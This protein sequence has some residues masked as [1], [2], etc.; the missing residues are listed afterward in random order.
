VIAVVESIGSGD[1][2]PMLDV[3]RRIELNQDMLR[4]IYEATTADM[5]WTAVCDDQ[6]AS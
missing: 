3:F 5:R 1:F 6:G 2:A 4:G